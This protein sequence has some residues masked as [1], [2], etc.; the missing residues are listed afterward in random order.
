M[1]ITSLIQTI[2]KT[3]AD[4]EN[5][6]RELVR[7]EQELEEKKRRRE[8][9]VQNLALFEEVR[10]FLQKLAVTARDK[11]MSG[12]QDVVTMCLQ[13][14]FG[15]DIH[16]EIEVDTKRENTAVEFYVVNTRGEKPVRKKPD[17]RMGGGVVDTVAIGLRYGLMKV[18]KPEPKGPMGLDEPAKMVSPDRVESI[19]KLL[20]QLSVIFGKQTILVSHHEAL[21]DILD[22]PIRVR[23]VRGVSICEPLHEEA[24]YE[25]A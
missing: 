4:H 23:Q 22:N 11:V 17:K 18:V 8:E 12:L 2:D 24:S 5:Q 16:F 1:E 20:K 19:G 15:P 3:I 7:L 9:L 10:V 13:I 14:V 6:K 25:S 21:I